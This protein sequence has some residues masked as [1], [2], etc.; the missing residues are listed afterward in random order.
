MKMDGNTLKANNPLPRL[1]DPDHL[2]MFLISRIVLFSL[3]LLLLLLS[4][5]VYAAVTVGLDFELSLNG[6]VQSDHI[7]L[8]ADE[9][10]ASAIKPRDKAHVPVENDEVIKA[11]VMEVLMDSSKGTGSTIIILKPAKQAAD[12]VEHYLQQSVGEPV[13][14]TVFTQPRSLWSF[15]RDKIMH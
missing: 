12:P 13:S 11:E 3:A 5:A 2:G 7:V 8:F 6:V 4:I 9:S 1:E 10:K 14:A 15:V